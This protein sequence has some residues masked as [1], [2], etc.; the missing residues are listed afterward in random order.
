MTRIAAS[1]NLLVDFSDERWRLIQL[2]ENA[3]PSLLVEVKAGKNF[4]YDDY[5]ASSR[6]LPP[7]GDVASN[8]IGQVVLGWSEEA[9]AWQLGMT[10]SPELSFS[11]SSRWFE[12][13][14]FAD[15]D[16]SRYEQDAQL[17]GQALADVLGKPFV[18]NP[19]SDDSLPEPIPLVDLPL[20]LSTWQ[21]RG[22]KISGASAA[23]ESTLR[24]IRKRRWYHAKYRQIAWYGLMAAVYAW[25]SLASL[26]HELGLPNAGTLIPDPSLLP[27]LGI[28]V[29]IL[30]LMLISRQIF[31]VLREPDTLVID[32]DRHSV[33]ATRRD[34]MRWTVDGEHVQSVYVSELVKKRARRADVY[35]GEINLHLLDGKF[36]R[37]V[38]EAEKHSDALLPDADAQ[39]EK[40]RP[41]GITA[42]H[43]SAVT[44][45]LQA[46]AVHISLCLGELPVWYDRRFK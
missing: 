28:A 41:D 32:A 33:R 14:R 18:A 7:L 29:S 10:L 26:T 8:D 5:F 27:Y 9:G 3:E 16:P 46:A 43:A 40:H 45:A 4:R 36:R 30:L 12:V 35:H 17:V 39:E 31:I 1:N 11:R 23:F 15:A 42:L 24:L 37:I 19:P 2:D 44:T 6:A 25:V 21:V 20:D 34:Q 38:V 13:L 22:D